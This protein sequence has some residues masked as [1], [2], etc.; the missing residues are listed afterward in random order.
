MFVTTTINQGIKEQGA[1]CGFSLLKDVQG[2]S[3][4]LELHRDCMALFLD[5]KNQ[6]TLFFGFRIHDNY[7]HLSRFSR[8]DTSSCVRRAEDLED[9]LYILRDKRSA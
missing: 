8:V 5:L 6:N 3:Q 7:S 9:V 4:V 2:F 1:E